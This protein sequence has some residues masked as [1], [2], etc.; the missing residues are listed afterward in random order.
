[1][2]IL[3]HIESHALGDSV[4]AA[5][6]ISKYQQLNGYDVTVISNH[7][8]L[9]IK[10]YPNLKFIG[11][12]EPVTDF[13][14][15]RIQTL[16]KF[17]IPLLEG[18]AKDFGITTEGV[19]LKVDSVEKQRPIKNKYV[20]IGV[21]STAQCKYWNYPG[22]WDILSKM[23][24]KKGLTPV[25]VERDELFG[26]E[27]HMNGLPQSAVKKVGMNFSDVLNYIQHCEFYIGLSSGLSWVAQ[28]LGKPTVIISNVTS[29][30]NEYIDEKTLRIYDEDICHGCIH[31]EPFD[32]NDWL[33]CPV[34]RNDDMRRHVCTKLITPQEVMKKIENFFKL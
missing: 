21:H 11:I 31:K 32:T 26:I 17:D 23:L 25:V 4:G 34:Y 3:V 22:G 20:C 15:D 1:M 12:D 5:A 28:G 13:Y 7:S 2:K 16:Y 9:F 27:G 6:I 14:N 33:W 29:K 8:K 18:Y 10:S 30:D 24:R 19:T